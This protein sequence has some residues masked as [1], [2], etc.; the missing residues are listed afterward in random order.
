MATAHNSSGPGNQDTLPHATASAATLPMSSNNNFN[1]VPNGRGDRKTVKFGGKRYD[2]QKMIDLLW[3]N[4]LPLATCVAVIGAIVTG[5]IIRSASDHAWSQR[6]LMYLEFPG[7]MFMR[8]L[9]CLTIPLIV[10]S[11]VSALGS[12]DL[13]LSGK[14][15]K[16]AIIY[17][18]ATTVISISLGITLVLIAHPGSVETEKASSDDTPKLSRKTT[19][20]DTILDLIRY[21]QTDQ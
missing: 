15:G 5:I 10:S 14:I 16:R 20:Q 1:S 12:L 4:A 3:E 7:E 8:A 19:T 13:R 11:L 17:Y 9:K 2:R 6:S 18:L 21:F